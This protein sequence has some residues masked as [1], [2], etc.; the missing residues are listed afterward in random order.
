MNSDVSNAIRQ[1]VLDKNV[2]QMGMNSHFSNWR[3]LL[4]HQINNKGHR[5]SRNKTTHSIAKYQMLAKS[6]FASNLGYHFLVTTFVTAQNG[7]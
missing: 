2:S 6:H 7:I 4:M 1:S 5:I 3:R